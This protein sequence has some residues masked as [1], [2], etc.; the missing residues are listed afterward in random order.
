MEIERI[1]TTTI[2]FDVFRCGTKPLNGH[3]ELRR[4][5]GLSGAHENHHLEFP[6][7]EQGEILRL[8]ILEVD[9]DVEGFQEWAFVLNCGFAEAN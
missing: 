3:R 2:N 1:T 9:K 4:K 6:P 5:F 7:L 8:D